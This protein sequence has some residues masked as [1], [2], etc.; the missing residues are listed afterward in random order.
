MMKMTVES[1]LN[2]LKKEIEDLKI[3]KN[4]IFE[5][6][7]ELKWIRKKFNMSQNKLAEE[8]NITQPFI[9][10]I[11]KGEVS[12]SIETLQK[13]LKVIIKIKKSKLKAIDI[14]TTIVDHVRKHQ[15]ISDAIKILDSKG[16]SQIVVLEKDSERIVGSLSVKRISE[17]ISEKGNSILKEIINDHYE[18]P[19][20]TINRDDSLDVVKVLLK[21]NDAIIVLNDD[22]SLAGI[23]THSDFL[24]SKK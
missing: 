14:A 12:P 11:E 17:L 13:M 22:S 1:E 23:I 6:K 2:R 21:Y 16:Y 24:K 10:R 18:K 15:R 9:A 7:D 8:A 5:T 3:Y 4:L 19:F 20:P